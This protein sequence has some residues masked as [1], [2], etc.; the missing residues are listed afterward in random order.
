[1]VNEVPYLG[2]EVIKVE[3]EAVCSVGLEPFL[4]VVGDLFGGTD[5]GGVG[6]EHGVGEDVAG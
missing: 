1:M 5:H 4:E 6:V 2:T 3:H